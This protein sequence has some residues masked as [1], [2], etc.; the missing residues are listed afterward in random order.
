MPATTSVRWTAA[1][2]LLGLACRA[3]ERAA[4]DLLLTGGK[5]FTADSARPWA[6]AIA[7]R[8]DRIV[9]VGST[10]TIDSL[11]GPTTRRIALGGRVVIP[12]IN[13]AHDHIGASFADVTFSADTAP[14]PDPP[15]AVVLDS[16]RAIVRRVP[17]EQWIVTGVGERVLDDPTARRAALDRIAPAHRVWLQAWTGH[18]AVLNSAALA[19]LGVTDATPDPVGGAYER[20]GGRLT[21]RIDEYAGY[22]GAMALRSRLPD[23]VLVAAVRAR[24]DTGLRFGITTIQNMASATNA[25]TTRRVFAAAAPAARIRVVPMPAT[26]DTAGDRA[27]WARVAGRVSPTVIVSGVKW[28]LDGTPVERL[29]ALRAPYADRPGWRGRINFTAD[30]VLAFLAD[31]ARR[32]EQPML[33]VA[34]DSSAAFALAMLTRAAPD[35]TW[36]RLRPRLEH[37]DGVVA[38]MLPRVR[39]LGAVIVQNPSHL[40]VS[41]VVRRIGAERVRAFQPLRSLLATGVPLAFGSDGPQNPFLNIFFATMHPGNPTEALT[42]EQAVAAYTRGSAYAEGM[43]REKGTIAPGYLADLAVLSQ[44]IFTAPPNALPG[45]TSILTLVG[46]R[47]V[48]DAGVV[49]AKTP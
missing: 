6:E 36:R 40:L 25:A 29:A 33:H 9:A 26:D 4:P 46:G 31:A 19:A 12:G 24:V 38:E 34:G 44:D 11:A 17:A 16:L 2:A 10:T 27:A 22:G 13:D 35:S 23:S 39:E 30:S 45:T 28:I 47:V 20:A 8:G 37:G 21:G 43:E 41:D 48:Y 18:G 14:V 5:V 7:I 3:G 15:I 49:G 32:G 1:I 42:V